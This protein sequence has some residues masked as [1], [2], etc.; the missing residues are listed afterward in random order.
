[1]LTAQSRRL[2]NCSDLKASIDQHI[3]ETPRTCPQ[4]GNMPSPPRSESV[5]TERYQW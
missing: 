2:Q 3:E 1:M 4:V 5:I